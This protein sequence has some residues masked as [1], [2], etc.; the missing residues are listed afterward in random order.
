M[1]EYQAREFEELA[2]LLQRLFETAER[3][4]VGPERES[5]F[6]NVDGFRKRVATMMRRY[7]A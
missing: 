5:A 1:S 4:P 6:R 2:Q 3:L 7:Q